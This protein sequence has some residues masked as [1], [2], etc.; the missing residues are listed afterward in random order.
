MT[1]SDRRLP[2]RSALAMIAL[3]AVTAALAGG[4]QVLAPA[5]VAAEIAQPGAGDEEC[6]VDLLWFYFE[7]C[8]EEEEDDAGGGSLDDSFDDGYGTDDIDDRRASWWPEDDEDAFMVQLLDDE[9]RVARMWDD[10]L[11]FKA[12]SALA[13]NLVRERPGSRGNGILVDLSNEWDT[14]ADLCEARVD[15]GQAEIDV[16]R[17][18]LG[19]PPRGNHYT[20]KDEPIWPEVVLD[21][22]VEAPASAAGQP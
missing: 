12:D 11:T 3:F 16:R 20:H 22:G 6:T 15:A 10:C 14:Q 1:T 9:D 4:V 5:S 18:K 13:W 19:L 8:S 17:V 2:R 7:L 21:G